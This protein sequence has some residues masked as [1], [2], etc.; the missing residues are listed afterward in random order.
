MWSG[1]GLLVAMGPHSLNPISFDE[2]PVNVSM[3]LSH[4]QVVGT[5]L[6][7]LRLSN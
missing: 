7:D 2:V 4:H 6:L 5:K 3:G 1:Y